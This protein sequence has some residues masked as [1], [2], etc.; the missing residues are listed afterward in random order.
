MVNY[1]QRNVPILSSHA[2]C[3]HQLLKKNARWN[4]TL[5]HQ[6]QFDKLK[7]LI[8]N[9][10][11]SEKVLITDTSPDGVWVQFCNSDKLGKMKSVACA[12]ALLS[13]AETQYVSTKKKL[14]N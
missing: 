4:W 12:S 13:K 3:V 1:F 14:L 10:N 9:S 2:Y 5:E 8:M 7:Q 11:P 6:H